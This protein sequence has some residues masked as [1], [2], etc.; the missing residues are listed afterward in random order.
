[1]SQRFGALH[2]HVGCGDLMSQCHTA[3]GI[4]A[5]DNENRRKLMVELTKLCATPDVIP[6]YL[7]E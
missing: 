1:M 5:D 6:G 3:T 4:M 2:V 7:L